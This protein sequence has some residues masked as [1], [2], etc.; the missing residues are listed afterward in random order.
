MVPVMGL[1]G[2]SYGIYYTP[3]GG[4]VIILIGLYYR[5]IPDSSSNTC[6][7]P[8]GAV[9]YIQPI[10]KSINRIY[11]Q[12]RSLSPRSSAPDDH[13]PFLSEKPWDSKPFIIEFLFIIFSVTC[14]TYGVF[15]LLVK[16][17]SPISESVELF[18]P[19]P[20]SEWAAVIG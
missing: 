17:R 14:H 10:Y 8:I 1:A 13:N 6:L 7:A 5:G 9:S 4:S 19:K 3:V 20:T 16:G 18:G 11:I 2:F 15:M 12:C